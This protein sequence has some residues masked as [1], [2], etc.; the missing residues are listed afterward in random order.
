MSNTMLGV[1][2]SYAFPEPSAMTWGK[3]DI[4]DSDSGRA[5]YTGYMYKNKI[6]EKI[7]LN[8]S[9]KALNPRDAHAVLSHFKDEYFDVTYFDPLEGENVTKNFYCGDMS[10]PVYSWRKNGQLYSNV[11]FNIIER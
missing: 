9:W 2:G 10:A 7:K 3:Q 6:G 1:N 11:A 8:L 4:S 5:Q